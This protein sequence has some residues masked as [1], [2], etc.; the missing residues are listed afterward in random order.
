MSTQRE[1]PIV[2]GLVAMGVVGAVIALVIG[3]M[4]FAGARVLG[5][6]GEAAITSDDSGAGATMYLPKPERTDKGNGP[7]PLVSVEPLPGDSSSGSAEEPDTSITLEASPTQTVSMGRVDLTGTYR[8]GEG[9]TLAV[10]KLQGSTWSD[11]AGIRATVTD[12]QFQTYIQTGTAG[13]NKFRMYD[14]ASGEASNVV[15]ITIG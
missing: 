5:L 9:A 6:N 10:Q 12:G 15:T 11:F 4:A 3:G 7:G 13:P 8:N 1:H 14:P 2:Q